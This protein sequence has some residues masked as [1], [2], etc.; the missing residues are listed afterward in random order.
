MMQAAEDGPRFDAPEGVNWSH[1]QIDARIA[2]PTRDD[3]LIAFLSE[4]QGRG[5]ANSSE[6]A[7]NQDNS[8]A[9]LPA[10]I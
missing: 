2:V 7:G 4:G 8:H 9:D 10:C 6:C 1:H 5:A 3:D